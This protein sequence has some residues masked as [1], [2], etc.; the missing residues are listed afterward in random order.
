MSHTTETPETPAHNWLWLDLETT[1]L[2][3][4]APGARI[5]EVAFAIVADG[6]LGDL[7]IAE[8]FHAPIACADV[9]EGVDPYVERMHRKSK[10]WADCAGPD[11]LDLAEVDAL[12][13]LTV[14]ATWPGERVM[15]AGNSVHFDLAWIRVHM[16]LL[17]AK[18]SHRVLDVSALQ[19]ALA[20]WLPGFEPHRAN[21][22]RA[23]A[24]VEASIAA[25]S[26]CRGAMGL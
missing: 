5:L 21:A 24:D 23:L 2:D 10:L 13:A 3:P 22:H 15:L 7:S 16:P 9:P 12:A 6:P 14:E 17:A 18:V 26:V 19:A 8:S 4:N 11:A 25:A 20:A 1:G